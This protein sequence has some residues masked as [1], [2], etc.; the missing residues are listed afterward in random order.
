MEQK[1]DPEFKKKWVA[2]LRSGKYKQGKGGLR[3]QHGEFCC[4]GVACDVMDPDAWDGTVMW[5]KYGALDTNLD[6]IVLGNGASIGNKLAQMNDNGKTFAQ[7]ADY[8]EENV[9]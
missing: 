5:R 8:I 2:A 4:L 6:F 7:I 1:L 9:H 3:N